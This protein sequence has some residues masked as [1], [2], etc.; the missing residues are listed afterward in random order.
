MVRRIWF[1]RF[2][3]SAVLCCFISP[4]FA[5]DPAPAD[6]CS[7]GE[8]AIN[9]FQW[10]P[11]GDNGAPAAAGVTNAIFCIG[12]VRK[13]MMN[14]QAATGYVGI[15]N[16]A[17][18]SMLDVGKAGTT[19]G[20]L[21]LE[22]NTSGYVQLQPAAA[23]GSWT[24]TLPATAGTSGY[25]LTTDGAGVLSWAA[26]GGA[27]AT[28]LDG[29]TAAAGNQAGIANG[30]YTIVW[31][32]DTLA[33]GSALKLASTSTAAASDAQKML[34]IALS[35]TNGT[36][37]Q[38]TYGIYA[39]NTH[40]GAT[41]TNYGIYG[42]ASSGT[43]ANYGVYGTTSSTATASSG[44]YGWTS[45]TTGVTYG[46]YGGDASATGSGGSFFN[47][48]GGYA[49][50]TTLGTVKLGSAGTAFTSMG[51]CTVA[52]YTPTNSA[53]TDT[54]TG[55]PASTAV[56]VHCS[57]SAAFSTITDTISARA[58]GTLNQIEVSLSGTNT[59]AVTLT[60][61]WIKP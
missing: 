2:L 4:V 22:G 1:I 54:C 59:T 17:P 39:S 32:W 7:A 27:G 23:A 53:V 11:T 28:T 40:A 33:G 8:N 15:G 41:S 45:G 37:G 57:Q 10:N 55:V 56:A 50:T 18:G 47:T 19:L 46:V 51:V 42:V 31:N 12:N 44:V 60:C 6:A 25:Q 21:R 5:A 16:T 35:G 13:S 52:S 58:N 29:I 14:F 9:T 61:M 26:A 36:A 3:L 20:T 49:L 30:A 24:A 34:E 43:T 48:N 38:S